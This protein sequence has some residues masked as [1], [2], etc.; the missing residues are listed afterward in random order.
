MLNFL[1]GYAALCAVCHAAWWFR[2][3]RKESWVWLVWVLCLPVAGFVFLAVS[4]FT[5]KAAEETQDSA[6]A[7]SPMTVAAEIGMYRQVDLNKELNIV[8]MEEVLILNDKSTKRRMLVDALKDESIKQ[9]R[10][11]EQAVLNED[12]ETSHYAA[13]A[14]L[15]IKRKLQSSMQ[16]LSKEYGRGRRDLAIMAP[17]ADAIRMYMESG[18]LDE[19]SIRKYQY[20]YSHILEGLVD[21]HPDQHDYFV[22][23]INCDLALGDYDEARMYCKTFQKHHPN[24]EMPYILEMKIYFAVRNY[25]KLQGA[26]AKLKASVPKL[27]PYALGVAR[28]WSVGA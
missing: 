2:K 14:I 17:Y 16:E 4:R 7:E 11:L 23:K 3:N 20:L 18:F 22:A 1:I 6:T 5:K 9:M 28:E 26:L 24:S 8:P 21:H 19:R 13:T 25:K 12:T 15:E 27:S 10:I